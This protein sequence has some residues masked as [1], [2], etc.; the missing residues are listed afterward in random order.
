MVQKDNPFYFLE[1]PYRNLCS[2]ESEASYKPYRTLLC[3]FTVTLPR[4]GIR[5]QTALAIAK[6]LPFLQ[7]TFKMLK[8]A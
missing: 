7:G 4:G 2:L 5:T 3:G 8:F 1:D 6:L